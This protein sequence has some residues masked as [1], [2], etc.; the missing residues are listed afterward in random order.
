MTNAAAGP[1]QISLHD[2]S[3]HSARLFLAQTASAIHPGLS[4]RTLLRYLFQYRAHLAAVVAADP[5]GAGHAGPP[6]DQA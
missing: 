3:V 1:A 4:A 5:Q 2:D 6:P